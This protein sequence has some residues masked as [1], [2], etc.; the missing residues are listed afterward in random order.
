MTFK[1]R[2]RY[3]APASREFECEPWE[4]DGDTPEQIKARIEE[5]AS[6]FATVH[7]DRGD[8][9]RFLAEVAKRRVGEEPPE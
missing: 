6:E 7:I 1:V 5:W 2:V 3:T 9:D 8:L 4:F